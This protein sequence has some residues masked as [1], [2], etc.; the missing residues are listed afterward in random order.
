MH[1]VELSES[2]MCIFMNE[3]SEDS[4]VSVIGNDKD[5]SKKKK[6]KNKKS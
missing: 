5:C 6:I 1:N 4:G 2:A 3:L